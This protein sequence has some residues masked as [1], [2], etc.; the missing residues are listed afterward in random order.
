MKQGR[1]DRDWAVVA[2]MAFAAGAFLV[3]ALMSQHPP[4]PPL[5]IDWPAWVQAIGSIAGIAT[6]IYVPWKQ[7][8]QARNDEQEAREE[9]RR[10]MRTALEAA[11][12]QYRGSLGAC[13]RFLEL[14]HSIRK[15]VPKKGIRRPVEFDQFRS[16]LHL[17]GEL[18]ED[19]N[20]LI[21]SH[22]TMSGAAQAIH[23]TPKF[24]PNFLAFA[25]KEFPALIALADDVAN[26]LRV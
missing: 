25:R 4:R 24:Q 18:G 11:V 21:A 7:R 23:S 3:W 16:E 10:V 19:V 14:D 17:L 9:K 15:E 26:R 8:Q 20:R 6:A 1:T 2:V 5:A 13:Y 22:T 12:R